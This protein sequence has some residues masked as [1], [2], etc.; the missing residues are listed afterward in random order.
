VKALAATVMLLGAVA[1]ADDDKCMQSCSAG[2]SR[3]ASTCA[4]ST[5][6]NKRCTQLFDDCVGR[7]EKKGNTTPQPLPAKCPG[8]HGRQIPCSDYYPSPSR[9][10]AKKN[11]EPR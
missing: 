1:A 9:P 8:P 4:T 3:C 2:I 11:V 7:C 5:S 10:P 6:C